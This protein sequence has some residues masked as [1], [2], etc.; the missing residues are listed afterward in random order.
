ME[1][2]IRFGDLVRSSGRPQITT[3]WTDPSKD[4][5]LAT[6]INQ[7]RVLTVLEGK[8]QQKDYGRLGF[9]RQPHALY[10]VF[11]RPLPKLGEVRVIGINYQLLEQPLVSKSASTSAPKQPSP[12]L[13]QAAAKPRTRT[14]TVTVRRVATLEERLRVE[15]ESR[16]AAETQ[17]L[18]RSKAEPFEP[19]KAVLHEEII[20]TE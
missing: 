11:P 9:E 18:K 12:R 15:A 1:R 8:G 7:N 14:F 13:P 17:A 16:Q 20:R 5:C 19:G 4:R 2:K 10:L 6:A 3:L